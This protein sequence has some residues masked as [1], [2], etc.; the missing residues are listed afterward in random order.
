MSTLDGLYFYVDK[1][2]IYYLKHPNNFSPRYIG[3]SIRPQIRLKE[4]VRESKLLTNTPKNDWIRKMLKEGF[5]P[6]MVILEE[7]FDNWPEREKYWTNYFKER[8]YDI[9]NYAEPGGKPPIFHGEDHPMWG[10]H[11]SD[12]GIDR[13]GNK[14][15]MYGNEGYWNGK[16]R[17]SDTNE[18]ISATL[19]SKPTNYSITSLNKEQIIEVDKLLQ[20]GKMLQVEIAK[21]FC[22]SKGMVSSIKYRRQK[23][24]KFLDG[25]DNEILQ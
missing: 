19:K 25:V 24:F 22:I 20:D 18:K 11:L 5:K 12:F 23:A 4:H 15:P 16:Q 2:Y 10:R 13:R 21:I 17:N 6:E 9:L 8:G 7:C 14:N 1:Q 3:V